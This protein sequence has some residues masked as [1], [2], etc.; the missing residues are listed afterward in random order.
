MLQAVGQTSAKGRGIRRA[1][2]LMLALA[3]LSAAGAPSIA[4]ER[5]QIVSVGGSITEI[6]YA[7]GAQ[8]RIVAVDTT[9]LY[10]PEALRTKP[11][12]GYLRALSAEGVLSQNPTLM[13]AAEGAGPADTLGLLKSAGLRVVLLDEQPSTKSVI[14]KIDEIGRLL[15]LKEPAQ[16]L[17]TKVRKEFEDLDARRKTIAKPLR[18]MVILGFQSGRAMAAGR[19]TA[20]DAMIALAGGINA[21]GAMDNYKQLSD[22]AVIDAAPD[23]LVMAQ[24]GDDDVLPANIFDHGAFKA[25]PAAATHTLIQMN[26]NYL[27]GFG[28]RT[29]QAAHE[30]MSRLYPTTAAAKP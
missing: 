30:L 10:P 4:A 7:L 1:G 17:S 27:L 2:K 28:P 16:A 29:A 9:S 22:E 5:L 23:A 19:K 18:V 21:A 8:E 14:D 12:V 25:T 24:R 26:A 13:I 6:I 3:L 15:D 20:A 11:N